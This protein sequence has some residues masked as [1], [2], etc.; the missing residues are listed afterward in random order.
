[1]AARARPTI[2]RVHAPPDQK[3]LANLLLMCEA[4]GVPFDLEDAGDPK[5]LRGC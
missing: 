1:M 5:K 4:L 3:K 2:F